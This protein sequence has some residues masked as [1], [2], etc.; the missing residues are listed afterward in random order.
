MPI[1][2]QSMCVYRVVDACKE[3]GE[4]WRRARVGAMTQ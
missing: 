2:V 1:C 3:I 4:N